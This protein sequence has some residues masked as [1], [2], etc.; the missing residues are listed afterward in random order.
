[1]SQVLLAKE[2]L[3]TKTLRLR[4]RIRLKSPFL[5]WV[6]KWAKTCCTWQEARPRGLVE[7][8]VLLVEEL[9]LSGSQENCRND[10]H[11]MHKPPWSF[12]SIHDGFQ[13]TFWN[14]VELTQIQR[15]KPSS[16]AIKLWTVKVNSPMKI[17]A[18]WFEKKGKGY[19]L[20]E[21]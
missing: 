16:T 18:C 13:N 2:G 7:D 1:M 11:R 6:K 4:W 9:V 19:D 3:T 20:L 8:K 15:W 14:C 10:H 21:L 5:F 12:G 17:R